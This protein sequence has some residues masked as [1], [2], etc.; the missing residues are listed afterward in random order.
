MNANCI[1]GSIHSCDKGY[2]KLV[3]EV[4]MGEET[5]EYERLLT[6]LLEAHYAIRSGRT[7]AQL[8]AQK[9]SEMN[10]QEIMTKI[11]GDG[12]QD[13]AKNLEATK[14]MAHILRSA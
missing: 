2:K 14:A 4:C 9:D 11:F 13:Q 3:N 6:F 10:G 1:N 5:E 8:G 7:W 12:L